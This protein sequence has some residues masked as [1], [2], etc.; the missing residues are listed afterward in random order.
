MQD[1]LLL[2]RFAERGSQAAFAEIVGR[3]LR[4]V[5]STCLR[6]VGDRQM[7]EDVTQGVFLILA[8][9]A[10]SLGRHVPL[11]GWLFRTAQLASK[12]TLRQEQRRRRREH[13][14][15]ENT[16][17]DAWPGAGPASH[18]DT[19]N[20]A[21]AALKPGEREA[22]LLRFFEDMSYKEVGEALGLSEDTAQ[23][24]VSRALDKMRAHLV[25]T[26][27][28]ISVTALAGVLFAEA[29]R[30]APTDCGASLSQVVPGLSLTLET[31]SLYGSRSYQISQGVLRMMK[32]KTALTAASIG[33]MAVASVSLLMAGAGKTDSSIVGTWAGEVPPAV[34]KAPSQELTLR[35][36]P[37]G[38]A[39]Q[40]IWFASRMHRTHSIPS[41]SSAETFKYTMTGTFLTMRFV[42]QTLDGKPVPA[43]PK[44]IPA[45]TVVVTFSDGGK[46]LTFHAKNQPPLVLTRQ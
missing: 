41:Y 34:N 27:E 44:N 39:T 28:V 5:H 30:S 36:D 43:P 4:L 23:K 26:G 15:V 42:R 3:Y 10:P 19:L 6:E 11:A 37:H 22:V 25:K 1:H 29:A 9:K 16:D 35:F 20:A 24:R 31:S 18:E 14:A 8:Q 38:T 17:G 33:A 40:E 32:V 7:A 46:T 45:D 21:L 12:S 13:A 2:R